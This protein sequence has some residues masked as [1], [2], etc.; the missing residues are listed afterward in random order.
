MRSCLRSGLMI[1]WLYKSKGSHSDVLHLF[2]SLPEDGS[3]QL[4]YVMLL[5]L[6]V[7]TQ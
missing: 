1:H 7:L 2:Q 4:K 6:R 3:L 5:V